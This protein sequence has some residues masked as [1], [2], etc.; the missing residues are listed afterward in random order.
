MEIK[1]ENTVSILLSTY[2]GA[3]YISEQISSIINQ[4]YNDWRLFIR[5]DGSTDETKT[6]INEFALKDNRITILSDNVQH[7]GPKNSFIWLLNSVTSKYY[8]FC[9]QDDVWLPSKIE[10]T[11][12]VIQKYDIH[13]PIIV[14]CDLLLVNKELAIIN[15][16]MWQTHHLNKLVDNPNGI[17]IASMF[18]GCTMMFNHSAKNFALAETYDFPMHDI[19]LSM[20][21]SKKGGK[22]IPLHKSLIKYRLHGNN[23]VGLYSGSNWLINKLSNLRLYLRNNITYYKI[24][25]AYLNTSIIQYIILKTKHILNIL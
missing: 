23:V 8:M 10:E 24:S 2:N 1:N 20:V 21:V 12:N 13:I 15:Y 4:S 6:I 16:S 11:M 19:H 17:R 14:C 22:I 9:D 3:D 7:R 18:P 25:N 5:D